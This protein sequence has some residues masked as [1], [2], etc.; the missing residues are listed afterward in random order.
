[1]I[2]NIKNLSLLT[3]LAST[4]LFVMDAN[5][6]M[7]SSSGSMPAMNSGSMVVA[8]SDDTLS[9]NVQRVIAAD[10]TVAKLP[11]T[12][13]TMNGIVSL[14]GQINTDQEASQLIEDA[15]SV[16]GVRDVDASKLIV[17]DS[18][19]PYADTVIT[20]KIKGAFIREQ[21]FGNKTV[22][23]MSIT[24]E[25]TNG[26]VYLTGT[27]DSQKQADTAVSLAKGISGVKQVKTTVQINNPS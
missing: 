22:P 10:S 11:V 20:A 24:V 21:L 1:M 23:M 18:T 3:V 15:S 26:I 5:A 8:V 6:G 16:T 13:M 27:A 25:T 9:A 17:K 14:S 19:Q 7:S 12:I 4:V 2:M